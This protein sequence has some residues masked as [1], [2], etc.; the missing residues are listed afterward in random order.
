MERARIEGAAAG[1]AEQLR[2]RAD[3]EAKAVVAKAREDAELAWQNATAQRRRLQ[4][5]A[6]ALA[7]L[8]QRMVE[9]LGR[10]YAPLGLI[11]VDADDHHQGNSSGSGSQIHDR[12][13]PSR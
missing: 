3:R 13:W 12:P 6:K 9:Q 10:L 2:A 4:A 5:E 8:R 7:T 11:V 1:A